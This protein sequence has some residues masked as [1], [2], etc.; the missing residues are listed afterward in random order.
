MAKGKKTGGRTKGTP[1]K[2]NAVTRAAIADFLER[3][4]DKLD[5]L[6]VRVAADDP[7]KAIQFLKDIAEYHIPKLA[8]TELTGEEGGP[9][10]HAIERRIVHPKH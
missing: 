8:R 3:Q 1:N 7:H 5:D 9:V 4:W 2:T 6:F 10:L